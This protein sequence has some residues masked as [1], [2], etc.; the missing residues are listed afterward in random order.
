MIVSL[1]GKLIEAAPLSCVIEAHGVGYEVFIPVT[2]A[3]KLPG[4][5]QVARLHTLA[6]YREDAQTLYGFATREDRDFFRLLVEKVSGIG[7][8]IAINIMSRMSV[9]S[10]RTAIAHSDVA[11]LSKCQGIGKKTAE[12]LVVELRDKVFP[13]GIPT[14]AAPGA[15]GGAPAP[16]GGTAFQD[17][18]AALVTLG[19]K[20]PEADK[21]L[22]KA[23][24]KLGADA[25]T[26]ALIKSALG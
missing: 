23:Q 1:E 11:L 21:A 14:P 24:D 7:P 13:G 22:R 18:L 4:I 2:T 15:P 12:R 9:E 26:E 19:Y 20:P 6:V 17:A 10:L 16:V 25:T 5:G 3:E 8:K